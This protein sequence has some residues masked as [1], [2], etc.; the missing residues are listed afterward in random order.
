MSL[1]EI[2]SLWAGVGDTA[3]YILWP[4][5]VYVGGWI[6]VEV[7]R[8]IRL[9]VIERNRQCT[10]LTIASQAQVLGPCRIKVPDV[11]EVNG[12]VEDA[13]DSP[14]H[15]AELPAAEAKDEGKSEVRP[16]KGKAA[17]KTA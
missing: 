5:V 12:T 2:K 9:W 6:L 1:G 16:T 17:K 7:I 10:A 13:L 15:G 14:K 8:S 4:T 3:Q 11:I